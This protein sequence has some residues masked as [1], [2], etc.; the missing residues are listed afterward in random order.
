M[1][2]CKDSYKI[3]IHSNGN[4]FPVS[5]ITASRISI[6]TQINSEL[7]LGLHNFENFFVTLYSCTILQSQYN[8]F[9]SSK[10]KTSIATN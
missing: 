9:Q 2:M 6:D 7:V 4:I 10:E 5:I 3:P 8:N 1:L